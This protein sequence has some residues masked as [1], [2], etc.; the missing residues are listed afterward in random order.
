[1]RQ[2]ILSFTAALVFGCLLFL[3]VL[4]AQAQDKATFPDKGYEIEFIEKV[5]NSDG[6]QTWTYKVT[7][8]Q[9]SKDLSN[10]VIEMCLDDLI[11]FS[12]EGTDAGIEGV[13]TTGTDPT[14]EVTGIKW[15]LEDDFD[16]DGS[17]GE[18]SREFSFTL[19][20]QYNMTVVDVG[21]KTG[22][23]PS[24]P[25]GGPPPSHSEVKGIYG[26]NCA[27]VCE[28]ASQVGVTSVSGTVA[29]ATIKTI[30]GILSVEDREGENA[31]LFEVTGAN[32]QTFTGTAGGTFT[33]DPDTQTPPTSIEAKFQP[34][35]TSN[36]DGQWMVQVS[37]ECGLTD[38]DPPVTFDLG[39]QAQE[40]TSFALGGSYPNPFTDQTTIAFTLPESA[41]V[42]LAVYDIMGRRVA[43][44]VDQQ[45]SPGTHRVTWSGHAEDGRRLSSGAYFYRLRAGDSVTTR[46]LTILR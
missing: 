3:P 41:S 5:D 13:D 45:M 4:D 29:T 39:D 46:R 2:R 9:G 22:G 43:S 28:A 14:T 38:L 23:K 32:G 6:T 21:V 15:D 24:N 36:P 17:D 37:S 40:P 1:M 31:E 34:T 25:G 16:E 10:W 11:G 44:L 33:L 42:R 27:N 12:P 20:K 19:A 26:P 30:E 8:L 18:D 35:N 7:E